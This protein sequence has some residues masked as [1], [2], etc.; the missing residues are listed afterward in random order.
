MVTAEA[1]PESPVLEL[2]KHLDEV[3]ERGYKVAIRTEEIIDNLV[4]TLPEE[5]GKDAKHEATAF[6]TR[7]HEKIERVNVLFCRIGRSIERL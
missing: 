4:G 1:R 2:E 3:V 5:E 6:I 7:M